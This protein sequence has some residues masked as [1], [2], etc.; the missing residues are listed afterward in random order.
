M[1]EGRFTGSDRRRRWSDAQKLEI[2]GE[3]GVS[4]ARV[5]DVARRHDIGRQQIYAWRRDLRDKGVL[6]DAAPVFVPVSV[7][8][9]ASICSSDGGVGGMIEV[10]LSKGRS[11]AV[12][13][14]MPA[15]VLQELIRTVEA[16]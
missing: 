12:T 15:G 10:R 14:D 8:A 5:S 1:G 3:V 4:G 9:S 11:L 13:T 16:A 2:V 6:D 7:A